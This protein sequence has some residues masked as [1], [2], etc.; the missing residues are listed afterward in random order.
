MKTISKVGILAG[1]ALGGFL[2]W[3]YVFNQAGTQN[4]TAGSTGESVNNYTTNY[5]LSDLF[6]L[7]GQGNST[8]TS[9]FTT[10]TQSAVTSPNSGSNQSGG[11]NF[12]TQS[13]SPTYTGTAS[14]IFGGSNF[15]IQSL[16]PTYTGT[17]SNRFGG[18]SPV[19]NGVM[20]PLS[21]P[22]TGTITTQL[23]AQSLL[24]DAGAKDNAT[25]LLG[26]ASMTTL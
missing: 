14:N 3:D 23:N 25:T 16:S 10:A 6:G 11:S 20:L 19:V 7:T 15:A 26:N 12:A 1:L 22:S 17:A 24:Q 18:F 2:L 5:N 13:L 21:V 8:N 4:T 9:P